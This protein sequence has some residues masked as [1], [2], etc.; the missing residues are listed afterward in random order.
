MVLIKSRR[1]RPVCEPCEEKMYKG[2]VKDPAFKKLFDIPDA[3]YKKHQFLR[4]IKGYYLRYEKLSERQL[5][6]FKEYVKKAKEN[7]KKNKEEK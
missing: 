3:M 1:Q 5:E 2:E 7:E 6:A 4:S